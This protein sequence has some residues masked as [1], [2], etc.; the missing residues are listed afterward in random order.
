ML[1]PS[2]FP[3][4]K[5]GVAYAAHLQSSGGKAPVHWTTLSGKLAP[6]LALNGSTGAIAGTPKA[7]GTYT[8]EV[9][10]TDSESPPKTAN[11]AVSI[12]IK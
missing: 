6:G 10:A 12:T 11:I 7:K 8:C 5:V 3:V 1:W 2:T 9:R 4:G